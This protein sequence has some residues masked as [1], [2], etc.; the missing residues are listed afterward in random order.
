V[1]QARKHLGNAGAARH[2]AAGALRFRQITARNH[3]GRPVVDPALEARGAPVHE[4]DC[5]LGLDAAYRGVDVLRD[6]VDSVQLGF[7]FGSC[8]PEYHAQDKK[9]PSMCFPT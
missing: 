5:A 4:L 7:T 8:S 6:D 2:H 3:C 9:A 1:V